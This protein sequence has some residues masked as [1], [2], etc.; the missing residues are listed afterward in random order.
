MIQIAAIVACAV[1]SAPQKPQ[2]KTSPLAN[3]MLWR[4]S[5]YTKGRYLTKCRA[6]FIAKLFRKYGAKWGVDP[7]L[8]ASVAYQE[9][10][11]SDK[12]IRIYVKRCSHRQIGK[13]RHYRWK[14]LNIWPG[15]R[16]MLQV[17]PY[18][19]RKSFFACKGRQ[20]KN[21]REFEPTETNIC[22]S[23]HLM[24][25]RRRKVRR[26]LARGRSF[27]KS[28]WSKRY[29]KTYG[30]CMPAQRKFCQRNVALC[31]RSW[32]VASW[33]WGSHRLVCGKVRMTYTN[34]WYPIW[35]LIRYKEMTKRFRQRSVAQTR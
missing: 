8:I 22:V 2:C 13:T 14:C 31:R 4:S 1:L 5:K 33:N 23:V 9:S 29:T 26:R 7:W 11:Y 30:P 12:P 16:G 10:R 32:W 15:E 21:N 18:Y 17:V 28:P 35:V 25:A 27:I 3:A 20:P 24:A 6:E 19:G 34:A